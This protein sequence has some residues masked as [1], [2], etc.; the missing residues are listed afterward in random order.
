MS[1]KYEENAF[2]VATFVYTCSCNVRLTVDNVNASRHHESYSLLFRRQ[3]DINLHRSLHGSVSLAST[4]LMRI[5]EATLRIQRSQLECYCRLKEIRM[6][7][8]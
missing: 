2:L 8:I 7:R 1:R 5:Y 4:R 3:V 6:V